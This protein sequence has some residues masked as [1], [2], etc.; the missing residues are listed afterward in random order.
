L[1]DARQAA[2]GSIVG[3]HFQRGAGV[4]GHGCPAVD[5]VPRLRRSALQGKNQAVAGLRHLAQDA[6]GGA[7]CG[8]GSLRVVQMAIGAHHLANIVRRGLSP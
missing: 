5:G 6:H 2:S 3:Q 7:A 1:G 8:N 4:G